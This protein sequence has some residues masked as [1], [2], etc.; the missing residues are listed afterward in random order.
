MTMNTLSRSVT[1]LQAV[2]INLGAIIGAGIFVIIGIAI[3][4][5]GPAIWVSIILSAMI[6]IFTGLSFAEIAR[7]VAKEG[8]VY[9]YAKDSWRP[10][11]GFIGGWLWT[12]GNI[13]AIAAVS[14]SMGSYINVLLNIHVDDVYFAIAAIAA[15]AVINVLGIKNSAKTIT[16]FVII[17][18][19]VL[20]IFSAFGIA[21][22]H[23]SYSAVA[24]PDGLN[25]LLAGAAIIFFAFTGFS[26]V[27]T[28]S[29][30][31]DNPESTI[32]KAII[33][34][35][36]ISTLIYI[37]VAVVAIGLV[38]FSTLAHSSAPLSTAIHTLHNGILEL[39]IA[40]GGIT[41]TAGVI[42]TGILG[43]SRV[44]FAMGRD[45]E[46]PSRLSYIDR[47]S[48]PINAIVLSS[49]LAII[50]LLLVSF[51]TIVD[52]S[53]A[54]VLTAYMIIDIAAVKFYFSLKKAKQ[55]EKRYLPFVSTAGIA[56]II[57][58]VAYLNIQS[59]EFVG[60]IALVGCIYYILRNAP[61][62]EYTEWRKHIHVPRHSAVRI[63]G[64][65]R[66]PDSKVN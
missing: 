19:A 33:I 45:N 28:I 66:S 61:R 65:S 42:L 21:H 64:S 47:F 15:F 35:I 46:L 29:D 16:I 22:Y 20:L 37:A 49:V 58:L 50:F 39:V 8:G 5:A 27:T 32:P 14:L 52:A 57:V 54:A 4:K 18:V 55:Q 38:P 12:F 1:L 36:I 41:A 51:G 31:V 43:T 34:S 59:L 62:G 6:A 53:N 60:A 7:H 23:A 63:F 11:A 10:F 30:E 17:N 56:T 9:E 24:L 25:G 40:V 26:R 13:I 3:G 44:F 2:M 48:T